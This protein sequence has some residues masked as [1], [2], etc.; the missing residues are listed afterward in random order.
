MEPN[1]TEP[2]GHPQSQRAPEVAD[3]IQL[4]CEDCG[5][6]EHSQGLLAQLG[7]HLLEHN[8]FEARSAEVTVFG[9]CVHCRRG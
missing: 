7:Q 8:S 9:L 1:R 6:V 4:V 2:S 3:A 5:A